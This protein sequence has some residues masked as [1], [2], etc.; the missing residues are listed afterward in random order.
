MTDRKNW[1]SV[2]RV[3]IKVGTSSI[4]AGSSD[5]SLDF[6]DSIARQVREIRDA[7][8]EVL[9][10]TSG[11]IGI[12]IKAMNAKPKPKE[13]PIRSAAASVG[14][15]IL[16][17][18][19]NDSFQKQGIVTAQIL[20]TM[21]FH[22]DRE[23]YLTLNNTIASLLDHNVVPIFNENDAICTREI[24]EVFGDNDTLS[25]IIASKMDADLLVILSDIDGL[26]ESNPKKDPSAAFISE[27]TNLDDVE[28]MAGDAGTKFGTGGM[29][30]KIAAARICFDAGCNMIIALGSEENVLIKATS[31]KEIGTLFIS[32]E[33][34][35]KKRRWLKS[36]SAS[37]RII[38][39]A[40]AKDAVKSHK[41]LLPI[42]I[43]NV[44]GVFAKGDVVEFVCE[45]KVF[46]KGL[47]DYSSADISKICKCHSNEISKALGYEVKRFDAVRSENIVLL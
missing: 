10:V 39:D 16:M 34:M 2:K 29:K 44:T 21:D 5:V 30:T 37:G 1:E 45:D 46:A 13:I 19:W 6:M 25:A 18:K 27:V 17:Q 12:G 33:R 32:G 7:G 4:T 26:Y 42:G 22:S 31:G 41:S 14:Q 43:V 20:I 11:A 40:G 9:L 47:P 36:A 3:V 15:S 38:V 8:A 23:K 35:D 24:G 28:G